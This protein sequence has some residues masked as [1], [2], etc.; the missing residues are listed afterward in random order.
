MRAAEGR[1]AIVQGHLVSHINGRKPKRKPRTIGTK[2]V[3]NAH[4]NIEQMA[5]RD[6]R[7][8]RIVVR[9]SLLGNSDSGSAKVRGA[10]SSQGC[11]DRGECSTAEQAYGGLLVA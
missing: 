6:S 4:P 11:G 2:Q 1:K 5:W 7:G 8:I 3:V 9:S 10:A